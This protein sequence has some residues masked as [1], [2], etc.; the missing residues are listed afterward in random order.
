MSLAIQDVPLKD[1]AFFLRKQD[2][3]VLKQLLEIIVKLGVPRPFKWQVQ[4]FKALQL[5]CG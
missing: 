1:E 3:P 5:Q 4:K 2:K